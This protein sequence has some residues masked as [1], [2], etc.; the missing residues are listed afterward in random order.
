M[1]ILIAEDD[2]TL[3]KSLSKGLR[4]EGFSVLIV[5]D[6]YQARERVLNEQ[7]D[8][9][10]FDQMLPGL[11]G[12]QLCEL[13]RF[14]KIKTPI[15][16]LSALSEA[17]DKIKALDIG[18]DDY[19]TKPFYFRELLSR[20]RALDRRYKQYVQSETA[21]LFCADL[22]FDFSKNRV[23]RNEQPINLSSKE[24]KLLQTLLEDKDK[25]VGRSKI[26]QKVWNT[27]E[28]TYTNV[29]DVYISY[30]RSKI[31]AGHATKLIRTV[32]GRGY[33][34]TDQQ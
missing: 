3:G 24:F 32:K 9:L 10:I 13:V 6:G 4:E 22:S 7:W 21:F 34:I 29:I 19:M 15:L 20:I 17:E 16:M 30:L 28:E 23:V 18:A 33:M 1:K 31:D 27:R 8:L 2:K 5:L 12:T 25:V 14:K 11:T 26:L